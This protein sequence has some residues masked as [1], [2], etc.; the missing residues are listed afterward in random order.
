MR[1]I[2]Q[3]IYHLFRL[4]LLFDRN[5]N[6][7]MSKWFLQTINDL[8]VDLLPIRSSYVSN[9]KTNLV[10]LLPFYSNHYFRR[11]ILMNILYIQF[12]FLFFFF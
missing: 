2:R 1:I 6:V 11:K 9:L 4:D 3:T 8:K 10:I 5:A 12:S 7:T